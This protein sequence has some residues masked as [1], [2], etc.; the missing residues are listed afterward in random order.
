MQ[1][2]KLLAID[3][4]G[5]V[6]RT[7]KANPAKD[8]REKVEGA[9]LTIEQ[10]FRRALREHEPT[11]VLFA[12]DAGGPTWRHALYPPYK[13]DRP[14][15]TPEFKEG[16]AKYKSRLVSE[17]WALVEHPD[18][19][20]DDTLASVSFASLAVEADIVVLAGD[21]DISIVAQYGA[22]VYDHYERVWH[23]SPWCR[24]K[25]GVGL[26]RLQDWLALVGDDV[27]GVPGVE[28]VGG[29]TATALLLEH[30]DLE[31]VL[32]AAGT[33]KGVVGKNLVEQADIARLSRQLTALRVDLF[34]QGL[35]WD[36]MRVPA[37]A[38]EMIA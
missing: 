32:A 8:E 9:F 24:A 7:Y 1:T 4:L 12:F 5:F 23:D 30:G 27:D 3:G 38:R 36:A 17:G 21:K 14:A 19:E 15:D 13:A 35:D 34:P 16:L 31:G 10:T 18:H 33:I 2:P 26:D 28:K 6:R 29:K 25:F 22:K 20:A 37:L 11:H